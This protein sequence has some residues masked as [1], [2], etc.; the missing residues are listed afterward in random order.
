M[1]AVSSQNCTTTINTLCEQ[2][3]KFKFWK[4]IARQVNK[5]RKR[6]W[7]DSIKMKQGMKMCVDSSSSVSGPVANLCEPSS[8]IK[9]I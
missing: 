4:Q 7:K 1:I 3:A 5:T 6:R 9:D 2:N 8:S